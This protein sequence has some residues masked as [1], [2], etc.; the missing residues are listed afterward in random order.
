MRRGLVGLFVLGGGLFVLAEGLFASSD[1]RSAERVRLRAHFDS[2]L[3]ELRVRDVSML[4]AS[5]KDA[6]ERLIAWL[7][8]YRDDGR[9]PL[10][11]RHAHEPTPIFRDARGV[12]C[13]MAYLIERSGRGDL[14][15][16]ISATQNFAY[17][18]E[19]ANDVSV[20]AWLDSVGLSADEAARIQPSYPGDSDDSQVAAAAFTVVLSGMS[21][22]TT[23]ANVFKPSEAVGFLGIAVGGLTVFIGTQMSPN[24]R[25]YQVTNL[26]SGGLAV[27]SGIYAAFRPRPSKAGLREPTAKRQFD[28]EPMVDWSSGSRQLRAGF[29]ARF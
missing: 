24:Q 22:A 27:V 12:T 13:A 1:H 10:N 19:L 26:V 2:V 15:D 11:D 8:D 21:V 16:R 7:G 9:F 4:S 18:R 6:R 17:I 14:V 3:V 23:I 5:R 29:I 20:V 25:G 28:W